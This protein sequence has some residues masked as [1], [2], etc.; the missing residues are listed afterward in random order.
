[1]RGSPGVTS[2]GAVIIPRMATLTVGDLGFA[3]GATVTLHPRNARNPSGANPSGSAIASATVT[4]GVLEW[5][6]VT[7]DVAMVAYSG[8][9]Y[10]GIARSAFVAATKW[11]D[12]VLARRVAIGTTLPG[13]TG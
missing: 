5:T 6:G 4:S 3:E 11:R 13:Y 12:K 8:G 10:V 7:D 9:R 1:M 2:A